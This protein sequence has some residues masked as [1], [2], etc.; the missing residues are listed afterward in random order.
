[1]HRASILPR[2]G[3]FVLVRPA[4]PARP[5]PP[6]GGTTRGGGKFSPLTEFRA[7]ISHSQWETEKTRALAHAPLLRA[8][9]SVCLCRQTTNTQEAIQMASAQKPIV[10]DRPLRG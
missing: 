2:N 7:T 3:D 9:K 10:L 6:G 4:W 8:G 1:M 5:G